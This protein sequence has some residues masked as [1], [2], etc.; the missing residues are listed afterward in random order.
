MSAKFA[1]KS[2]AVVVITCICILVGVFG[3]SGGTY[4]ISKDNATLSYQSSNNLA[5]KQTVLD[6]QD[7]TA[8]TV[9]T[10]E[11]GVEVPGVGQA[12]TSAGSGVPGTAPQPPTA[13]QAADVAADVAAGLYT[14]EDYNYLVACG[15]EDPSSYEGFYAVACCIRN[16]VQASGKSYRQVVSHPGQFQGY[17]PAEVGRPRN[18]YVKTAAIAVL[19]GGPSSVGSSQYFFGRIQGYDIWAE[20]DVPEFYVWGSDSNLKNVFYTEYGKLHNWKSNKSAGAIIIYDNTSHTWNF[21]DGDAY[22]RP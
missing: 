19:R 21:K 4:R 22:R 17:D 14:L 7:V 18:D 2:L 6:R 8:D 10:E 3:I 11:I 1:L 9:G 12:G 15:G 5:I 13:P 20:S 16:R